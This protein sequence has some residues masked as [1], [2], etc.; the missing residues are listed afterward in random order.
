VSFHKTLLAGLLIT[1]LG[2]CGHGSSTTTTSKNA[3]NGVMNTTVA[4]PSPTNVANQPMGGMD[5]SGNAMAP[6]TLATVP[7]DVQC[8]AVLPVWVNTSTHVY[9]VSTDPYYGRTKHGQYMCPSQA[10]AAGY[11]ASGGAMNKYH[12]KSG[13]TNGTQGNGNGD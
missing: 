1:A 8:G 11:H 2:A 7:P 10:K 4:N 13:S 3:S 6:G 9:H 5:N 12:R